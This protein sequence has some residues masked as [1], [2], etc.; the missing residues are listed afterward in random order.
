MSERTKGGLFLPDEHVMA[1]PTD[2]PPHA[3]PVEPKGSGLLIEAG[4]ASP[5]FVTDPKNW[6]S[7][8]DKPALHV[9]DG[10]IELDDVI[11]VAEASRDTP[12]IVIGPKLSAE[13]CAFLVANRLRGILQV[14]AIQTSRG[15]ELRYLT[16]ARVVSGQKT[17]LIT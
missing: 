4:F 6:W 10:P 5:Y 3:K 1:L 13:A 2:T 11:P 14:S 17:T 7:V 15:A 9:F 12:F 16:P 8:L